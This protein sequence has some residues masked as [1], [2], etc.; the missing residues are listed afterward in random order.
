MKEL[1]LQR[2]RFGPF[3]LDL[4]AAELHEGSRTVALQEQP[5]RVLQLILEN[6]GE[7][8]TREE[9]KQAL[10]PNDTVVEFD[11]GINTAIKKIRQA[12]SDSAE[13][14]KY[15]QT[16]ARRGY[17]FLVA[18][19]WP[20]D[21]IDALGEAAADRSGAG[22]G[23]VKLS[24]RTFAAEEITG[25]RL[26]H[27]RVLE[28]LG[29]GG[30]GVI[31]KALDL[32]LDRLVALKFLPEELGED[33]KAIE[34]FEREARAAS[35]LD[36]PNICSIYEFGE[37]EGRP[38]IVMPLLAGRNLNDLL[39]ESSGPP[40]SAFDLE[41]VLDFSIQI[42]AGL[43]AAHEKG[44]IH[45]DIKPANIF[46]T[47]RCEVKILDFGIAKM[48][49]LG[50]LVESEAQGDSST[51]D[52]TS[53]TL[54]F[55]TA[56]PT[57]TG[58]VVGTEGYMS[59]EQVRGEKLDTRTDLFSFGL[60]MY[61]MAT[62]QRA[63]GGDTATEVH[64]AI[65]HQVPL[66]VRELNPQLPAALEQMIGKALEKDRNLR[67]QT[68]VEML[69]ELTELKRDSQASASALRSTKSELAPQRDP[70]GQLIEDDANESKAPSIPG[71]SSDNPCLIE[72][73][74]HCGYRFIAPIEQKNGEAKLP[75]QNG[76]PLPRTQLDTQVYDARAAE[77]G[78]RHGATK[79][80][81]FG[82]AVLLLLILSG[83]LYLRHLK[84][85]ADRTAEPGNQPNLRATP[86]TSMPG[87]EDNPSLSPDGGQVAFAWDGGSSKATHRFDL[88][89]KA[90]GSEVVERLTHEPATQIIPAW[91]PDGSTIAFARQM[92]W[93]RPAGEK[94]GI[95]S[96]SARG[97]PERKLADATFAR[98]GGMS[99]SWSSDG[100]ELLYSADGGL[101][102]L[103]LENGQVR[104]VDTGPCDPYS[105]AFSPDGKWIAFSCGDHCDLALLS[106]KG[107]VAKRL[108]T[109]WCGQVA[110][111]TD[112]Q[113]LILPNLWE[114]NINGGEAHRMTM[115]SESV[116]YPTIASRGNRLAY[117]AYQG[118]TNIW[119]ADT[120]TGHSR[121]VFAPSSEGQRN[122]QI[123]PDA[124]RIAFESNRSGFQEVWVANLD[125]SDAL[126][127]SN[128]RQEGKT[129]SPRWSPDGR[130]IAF[131]SRVSGTPA[132]YLV[133]PAT[134]FPKQV[135]TNGMPAVMPTWSTDGKWLYFTSASSE[136]VERDALYRVPP[137]GGTPERVAQARGYNARQSKDGR[138]LYFAAGQDNTPINVLNV[139]TGELHALN[140]MPSLSCGNDW[141]LGSKG[142]F[143]V[144][145]D[146]K[147]AIDFYDL[148][149]QRVTQKILF[150]R[151]PIWWGGL[152]LSPDETWLAYSQIDETSSHLMLVQG[153]R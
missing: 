42:A 51:A 20:V 32:K 116:A 61:E 120:R 144:V 143:F 137:K 104:Q 50:E 65:M 18:V 16:V 79:F 23:P 59:P 117:V 131:D 31:Y 112:S 69:T 99:L 21:S 1:P 110:W 38:F 138:L 91:S 14:P 149:T 56:D 81:I 139:A 84:G 62:G 93:A 134:A 77:S 33:Q 34:R 102:I 106:T 37:H 80:S 26:S 108:L 3:E 98:D 12:L 140:G 73:L 5:F 142:I 103:T 147:P 27:Y 121:T 88:Y 19:E 6:G 70:L 100:R 107:G 71:D 8:T 52:A 111:T 136:P 125:G 7:L 15:I 72:T 63:F 2:A 92:R 11:H 118:T 13:D 57:R 85:R 101:H 17:R 54:T 76:Q 94:E 113:R 122:P 25:R 47:Q 28:I 128:F 4:K 74:P 114:I 10:W 150:D 66:G 46:I 145:W 90:T 49:L 96:V 44:I 60:V 124:K 29:G 78:W 97:G 151:Q 141:A 109:G 30:M 127:L 129:G 67:Y 75:P 146:P 41:R 64:E 105:S 83:A 82:L 24:K 53:K 55:K 58:T 89:V 135:S 68:A 119:R 22:D 87:M 45:R 133:D 126:Q 35:A 123:S 48:L 153:F 115:S 36:H 86:L 43:E 9:I 39:A 132:L 95:F 130:R 148:S 152:S 40:P